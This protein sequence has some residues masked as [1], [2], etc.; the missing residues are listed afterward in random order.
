LPRCVIL[1]FDGTLADS[2][3]WF[4][5][6]LNDVARRW[7][8][9]TV[10]EAEH[11]ALRQLKATEI[12]RRLEVPGWKLPLIAADMRRRMAQDIDRIALFDGVGE[13]LERLHATGVCLGLVSSNSAANIRRVLGPRLWG[14][15][16]HRECGVGV[17]AKHGRLTQLL[18]CAGFA[19]E[20]AIYIGDEV[21]DID[22]ARRAGMAVGVVAWGYNDAALLRRHRPDLLFEQVHELSTRLL[23]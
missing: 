3:P 16:P 2:F 11:A 15:I 17:S 23:R 10:G 6:V 7:R 21:R 4:V 5:S 18:R 12:F 19:P 13:Q 20:Q 1:D 22:A 8:F 14:L 9:K